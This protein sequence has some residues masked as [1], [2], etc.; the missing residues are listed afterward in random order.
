MELLL[1][2]Y[3]GHLMGDFV[4]Q[5]GKLVAAKRQGVVG[6]QIHVAVIG[7]C[8]AAVLYPHLGTY[9]SIVL[10]AMAAH[11]SIEVVTLRIREIRRMSGLGV[12][13]I[14]QGLH[15]LSLV[16]LVWA[17]AYWTTIEDIRPFGLD[18]DVGGL[19]ITTATTA[20]AFLGAILVHET[21]NLFGPAVR[22][23]DILPFDLPRVAGMAERASAFLLAALVAPGL[24]LLPFVPR[25]LVSTRSS[26]EDSR[27]HRLAAGTGLAL[28]LAALLLTRNIGI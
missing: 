18:L 13:I 25:L 9:W 26:A 21:A 1:G 20:T 19:A 16:T 11:L 22:R 17:A 12:F 6:L 3:L 2:L 15:A 28:C 14:D 8:T 4:L 23:R 7:A 5:P 27:Y 24:I 10:L